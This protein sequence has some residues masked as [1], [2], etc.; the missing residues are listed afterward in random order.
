MGV[1]LQYAAIPEIG[2][3]NLVRGSDAEAHQLAVLQAV[4]FRE[5]RDGG[6]ISVR[7]IRLVA[8]GVDGRDCHSG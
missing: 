7:A 3:K 5:G 8:R 2:D 6:Y 1:D 4:F